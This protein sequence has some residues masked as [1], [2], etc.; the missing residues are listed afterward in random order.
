MNDMV[1]L[2]WS[3]RDAEAVTITTSFGP[4]QGDYYGPLPPS[5]KLAVCE[6]DNATYTLHAP[7]R[8][9]L[10]VTVSRANTAYYAANQTGGECPFTGLVP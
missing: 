8:P 6:H 7:A 10:Q 3:V 2:L 4:E 9:S 5:G 1:L